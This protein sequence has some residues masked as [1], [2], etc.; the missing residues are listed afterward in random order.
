MAGSEG[1]RICI[2]YDSATGISDVFDSE[3]SM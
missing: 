2:G 3:I 1:E